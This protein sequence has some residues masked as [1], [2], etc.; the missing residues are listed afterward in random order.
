M[1][2]LEFLVA[3]S[4]LSYSA[5][6]SASHIHGAHHPHARRSPYLHARSYVTE[7]TVAE[8]YDFIIAGGGLAGLVLAARLSENPST[9]VLVLEAGDSGDTVADRINSPGGAYYQS[10]LYTPYDWQYKTIPQPQAGNRAFDWPRGKVLGGSSAVNAMYLVR[11]SETEVNEW[12]GLMSGEDSE[13]AKPW[14][15]DQFYESMKRS[16]TF[17]PP[18]PDTETGGNGNLTW[19]ASTHGTSGPMQVSYPAFVMSQVNDWIPSL[20]SLGIPALQE[21]NGGTTL[22]A[23]VGPSWINPSNWTRS[24]SKA[25]YLDPVI[26]RENLAVLVNSTVTR[27]I[28]ADASS[29]DLTATGVE[30]ANSAD[31]PRKVVNANREVILAGGVVGSPQILMLSGVGPR[32]VLEAAGVDVKVELPG[33]GQHLQDHLTAGVVWESTAETAGNINEAGSDFAKTPKFLSFINAATAWV[34]LTRL[35]ESGDAAAAFQTS[36]SSG[37]SNFSADLVPSN[38]PEVVE[39][40]KKIN[41]VIVNKILNTD[42]AVV[43]LLLATNSPGVVSV[44]A[45][46]QHPLSQG[47]LYINTSSAFD[48][49]IIDPQYFTHPADLIIMRQGVKLVRSLGQAP[50]LN[51]SLG[52]E[53]AP[54]PTVVTDEQVEEWLINQASTQYHPIASCAMLPKSQGG[55]VNAKLQVYGL[56]NVRVVDASIYPFEFAS[57]VGAS[58]YGLAEKASDIILIHNNI[59]NAAP[60]LHAMGTWTIPCIAFSL[61]SVLIF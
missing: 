43:E 47:R 60:S 36:L 2:S 61:A 7:E 58:T 37:L 16:E 23:L 42:L 55:V 45:A 34:N 20:E 38:S 50:P 57:H 51:G 17:T 49:P 15:W 22:G 19:S 26:N 9:K 13:A 28:F 6:T 48:P 12:E 32:D 25:A 39:G 4:V 54:G 56:A 10:L 29:G 30:F 40:Y 3:F 14:G 41:D 18:L 11:P 33:V 53:V 31:G 44:Q 35:F 27:I 52:R 24:Y 1:R 8:S 21:P 5:V 46:I 59:K